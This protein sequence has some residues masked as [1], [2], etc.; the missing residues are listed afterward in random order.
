LHPRTLAWFHKA[1][2][3]GK[4]MANFW[5]LKPTRRLLRFA[6][7]RTRYD[8]AFLMPR[9]LGFRVFAAVRARVKKVSI[10]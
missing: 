5:D 4:L 2:S 10:G 3:H 9:L 7:I 6:N 1:R 8:A